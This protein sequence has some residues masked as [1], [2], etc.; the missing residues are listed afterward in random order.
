MSTL[1]NKKLITLIRYAPVAVVCLFSISV[2]IIAIQDNREKALHSTNSLR[3]ELLNQRREVVRSQVHQVYKQL[4]VEKSNIRSQLEMNTKQRVYEAYGIAHHIYANNR[5]KSKE[6]ISA[7]ISEA[8]RPIRF[9]NGRGYYFVLNRYAN[10]VMH[11][12][13]PELEG[14]SLWNSVDSH[15]D[16]FGR[17]LVN[18]AQKRGEG[19]LQWRFPKPGATLDHD[20]SKLG[21]VKEF[22]PYEWVIGTGEY[23]SDALDDTK[24]RLLHWFS[25]YEYGENGYFFVINKKDGTLL[26]LHHNDFMGL[27]LQVGKK[28]AQGLLEQMLEQVSHGGGFITF[29]KPLTLSGKVQL[30]QVSYVRE[31]NGWDWI[32]GTGFSTGSFE[33]YLKIK[34]EQ[35][36]AF[37]RESLS[38]LV[39]LTLIS[40][41]LLIVVSLYVSN[42]IARRFEM[43]QSRITKDFNELNKTK[44]KMEYMAL[45]D[46]LT[47][48]P[49]RVSLIKE[50]NMGVAYARD[51][52][53]RLAVMFVDLDN[54]KNVNDLYGHG[55]GD[56][57][58]EVVSR[59]FE[60]LIGVRDLVSRFGGDE[61]IF[62][63][64]TIK[65]AEETQQ[66]AINIQNLLADAIIIEGR[67]LTTSCS[68]G[69]A[70]YPEDSDDAETLISQADTVL[71]R[72]KATKKGSI[73]FYDDSVSEQIKYRMTVEDELVRVIKRDEMYICYQPQIDLKTNKLYGVEALARW[74]NEKL[75]F[76]SPETFIS[77]A[78][79]IG[80]IHSLGFYLFR[81]A[82]EGL[83]E[84]FPN[85]KEAIALSFN[86][87]PLQI[88]DPSFGMSLVQMCQEIGI[89]TDR[90][91]LEVTENIPISDLKN[92]QPYLTELR[93]AG[94]GLSLDD[95]GTGYSSLSYIN[96]LP[97]T[98]IKIDR[99]FVNQFL[100]NHQTEMLV[101][102]ILGIGQS[103]GTRVVSEG[104]ETI[105]EL[106]KL[107]D[108]GCDLAQG[109]YFDAPIRI[110]ELAKKCS[111][112]MEYGSPQALTRYSIKD[113]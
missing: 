100:E 39:V 16:Y 103:C 1:D 11:G 62:C 77:I 85:G 49:N 87:S 76:V 75:G 22:E 12:V 9:F 98:E 113:S 91:T 37:N 29:Q 68:I 58:L 70:M 83:I 108:M 112:N 31:V 8:L 13:Q 34:E 54:F 71:Y 14:T 57:L 28:I 46:E 104:V 36:E 27:D 18:V 24:Q 63:F 90:I 65:S 42:L 89:D 21:F 74:K 7:L 17:D 97:L 60:S 81:K 23:L 92:I 33:K 38:K 64:P 99:A 10:N 3:E 80:L 101:R 93:E 5:A 61:F 6:E 51:T 82:C 48:L 110:E 67:V 72:V 41:V 59:K 35:L 94:F 15:G 78:E 19:F 52:K 69:V 55:V 106:N 84:K 109:Y 66:I 53:S 45:H 32:I 86:V 47:G 2:N 107:T 4:I 30:E 20:W 43:F 56:Q 26:S 111:E 105:E 79:E 102:M 25:E 40:T 96:N 88:F 50:I 95:F 73:L 44:N